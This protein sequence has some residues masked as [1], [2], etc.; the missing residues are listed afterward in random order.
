MLQN[1]YLLAKIGAYTAENERHFAENFKFAKNWKLPHGSTYEVLM[2]GSGGVLAA[3]GEARLFPQWHE[4][5]QENFGFRA[6]LARV[7]T[8]TFC[9]KFAEFWRARSRLYQNEIL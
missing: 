6:L 7:D 9:T 3:Q 2:L 5:V 1:A 4:V 8:C